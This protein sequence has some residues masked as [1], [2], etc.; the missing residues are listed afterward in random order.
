MDKPC[1][2]NLAQ[3][4]YHGAEDREGLLH[5][6]GAPAVLHKLLKGNTLH[7]FHNDV[8]GIVGQK[9]VSYLHN[10]RH[11]REPG[12][13]FGLPEKPLL[14]IAEPSAFISGAAYHIHGYGG[15]P[16]HH[17]HGI[18]FLDG[19]R[20]IQIQI[21]AQIGN[22][23]AALSQ[24]LAHQILLLQHCPGRETM[25]LPGD[26]LV[27]TAV[28]AHR[29]IGFQFHAAIAAFLFHFPSPFFPIFCQISRTPLP[30]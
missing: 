25:K 9:E 21:P 12:Q 3:C 11:L 16:H 8:G 10:L 7:I 20:D 5:P 24:H 19:Y 13:H 1:F 30:R 18:I 23:K 26:T 2:V 29:A 28:R 15:I 27:I 22:A 17:P 14:V 4:L 6:Q